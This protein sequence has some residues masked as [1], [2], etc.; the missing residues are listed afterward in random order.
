MTG[1]KTL[2]DFGTLRD[3]GMNNW[4][5]WAPGARSEIENV[6]FS[7]YAMHQQ[8]IED[9]IDVLAAADNPNDGTTQYELARQVGLDPNS[10]TAFD[11]EYIEREVAKKVL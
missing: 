5:L 7:A 4:N 9:F 3:R 2:K 10:L 1:K 6:A 11:I 8:A